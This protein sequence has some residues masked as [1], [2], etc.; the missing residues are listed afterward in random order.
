MDFSVD[1]DFV[2]VGAKSYAINK[3]NSVEVREKT[4]KGQRGYVLLWLGAAFVALMWLGSLGLEDG[5]S[6]VLL[7]I[8]VGFAFWGWSRFRRRANT[9]EYALLLVTS[10]GEAQ[11]VSTTD[12]G[13]IDEIRSRI[14]AAMA[15]R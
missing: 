13:E 3:I 9:T 8:A 6:A 7:I 10:S 11:A 14:E 5:N 12:A 2:R 1:D 4:I 15:R